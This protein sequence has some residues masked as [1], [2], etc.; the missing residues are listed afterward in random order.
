MPEDFREVYR[1]DFFVSA[2]L[3]YAGKDNAPRSNTDAFRRT[4]LAAPKLRQIVETLTSESTKVDIVYAYRGSAE[5]GLSG[6]TLYETY[7]KWIAAKEML[8]DLVVKTEEWFGAELRIQEGLERERI[9]VAARFYPP[10]TATHEAQPSVAAP[11]ATAPAATTTPLAD[12]V[13]NQFARVMS[14]GAVVCFL[15]LL[16]GIVLTWAVFSYSALREEVNLLRQEIATRAAPP[17]AVAPSAPIVI[18][19]PPSAQQ[20]TIIVEPDRTV[21]RYSVG[22]R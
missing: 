19:V 14:V 11:A 17:P 8:V 2:S 3:D 1:V 22:P 21:R 13:R 9:S 5:M 10:Q 4:A 7:D 15:V 6:R 16:F 12:E 20:Q 18:T